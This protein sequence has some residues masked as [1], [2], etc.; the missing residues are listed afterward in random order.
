MDYAYLKLES[1]TLA[2][3]YIFQGNYEKIHK[4]VKWAGGG[5]H[6]LFYRLDTKF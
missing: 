3:S 6:N 1:D 4:V 5:L 2:V